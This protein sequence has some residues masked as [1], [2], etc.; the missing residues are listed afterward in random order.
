MREIE[1][2]REKT[3]QK[4]AVKMRLKLINLILRNNPNLY[5]NLSDKITPGIIANGSHD[6]NVSNT[7][8]YLQ[9]K[10]GLN[11]YLIDVGANIG[12]VAIKAIPNVDKVFCF[13]PNPEALAI[14]N[15]N[16]NNNSSSAKYEVFGYAL[17]KSD[18]TL[19]MRIP[20]NNLG[21]GFIFSR[22]NLLTKSALAR[23][24]N[25]AEITEDTHREASIQ[26]KSAKR[27][28]TQLLRTLD[29]QT[30]GI[31]KIDVEGMDL[32]LVK[33]F[34]EALPKNSR[35]AIIF[36]NHIKNQPL[37]KLIKLPNKHL[38]QTYKIHEKNPFLI[39]EHRLTKLMKSIV[40]ISRLALVPYDKNLNL[41]KGDYL[42]IVNTSV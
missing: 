18:R 5:V 41:S 13:E 22:E 25:Y 6:N 16:L 42:I 31:L 17:G 7:I 10:L 30:G 12:T 34:L 38:L 9:K 37:A 4:I 3:I 39:S 35:A 14:L 26:M 33:E 28:F 19:K 8:N 24:D 32:F 23:K 2:V 27:I 1:I 20:I 29:Q 36:E 15:L 11:N 40:G 21:G